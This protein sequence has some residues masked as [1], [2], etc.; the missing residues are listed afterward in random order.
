MHPRSILEDP[1]LA[2]SMTCNEME[3]MLLLMSEPPRRTFKSNRGLLDV[4]Q[5]DDDV[6]RAMFRFRREEFPELLSGLRIL[7]KV[8]SAQGIV[9]TGEEALCIALRRL[10]YPNRWIDL[11]IFLGHGSSVLSS[12][13]TKVYRHIDETFA[14]LLS[15]L[16]VHRWLDLAELEHMSRAVHAKGAPLTNCWGFIDGTARAICRPSR[17]QEDHFFWP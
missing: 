14:I 10:A 1:L 3:D 2:S 8:T 5:L 16:N 13:A 15:D 4:N 9:V 12:I 11:E 17:G 6:F 7:D